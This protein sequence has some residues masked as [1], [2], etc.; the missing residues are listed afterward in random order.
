MANITTDKLLGRKLDFNEVLIVPQKSR[1]SSRKDVTVRKTFSFPHSKN[2]WTGVP[3]AASNMETTGTIEMASK[4]QDHSVLTCLHKY[5]EPDEIP[6]TLCPEFYALSSGI[7]DADLSRLDKLL[8]SL[9][10]TKFICIDVANGY[11]DKFVHTCKLLRNRH[12]NK[13]I[14]A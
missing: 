11:M 1:I 13:I 2:T 12:P 14:I 6:S 4:L 9:P 7:L 10:N 5:Y 3:I 8:Q